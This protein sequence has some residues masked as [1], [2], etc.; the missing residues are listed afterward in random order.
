MIF[1]FNLIAIILI[2]LIILWF[3]VIKPRAKEVT[4]NKITLQVKDG[5]YSPSEIKAKANQ[6]IE[7]TFI[8]RDV[9][10]CAEHVVFKDLDI[11]EKLPL[12]QKH[13]IKLPPLKP[14]RYQFSCPMNMYRGELIIE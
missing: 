4:E 14:G 8:R 9:T 12:N 3:W 1:I 10:P 11:H 6:A 2:V 13:V 7:L 5:T